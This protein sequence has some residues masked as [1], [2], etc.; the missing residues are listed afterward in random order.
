MPIINTED[1]VGRTYPIIDNNGNEE[2]ITIVDVLE[3]HE[4]DTIS[5]PAHIDF[6]SNTHSMTMKILWLIMIL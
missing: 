1:L 3:K 6:V 4:A 2:K 5:D